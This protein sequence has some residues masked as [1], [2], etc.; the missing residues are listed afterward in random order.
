M[1]APIL[2]TYADA[3]S[4]CRRFME[5]RGPAAPAVIRGAIGAAYQSVMN[6]HDWPALTKNH[7]IQL[8]ATQTTGSVVFDLTGGSSERLLTLTD[9]TFPTDA[10]DYAIRFDGI[11]CDIEQY[12][13]TTTVQLDTVMCPG[14]DVA[15]TSYTLYPR[16][17]ALPSDFMSLTV[18]MAE[19]WSLGSEI[20]MTKMLQM[21]RLV[22]STGNII[23]FAVAGRPDTYGLKAIFVWPAAS[24]DATLDFIYDRRPRNLRYSGHEADDYAGTVTVSADSTSVTGTSSAFATSMEGA[25]LRFG[26]TAKRP[27]WEYGDQPYKEQRSI[28]VVNSASGAAAITLDANS[29]LGHTTVRYRITDPIDLH[30]EAH[31]AFLRFCEYNLGIARNLSETDKMLARANDALLDA[32]AAANPTRE[33]PMSDMS[34]SNL[35][36]GTTVWP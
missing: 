31:N 24:S 29:S 23:H 20:T 2:M 32:M 8:K 11:V 1:S 25:I 27:D 12:L 6:A 34:L 14:A 35:Y 16:W 30:Q 3:F 36:P 22:P 19:N 5:R 18:P 33:D 17:Y 15:S 13:T 9:E 7:R 21:D 10:A 4:H 28:R 26:T